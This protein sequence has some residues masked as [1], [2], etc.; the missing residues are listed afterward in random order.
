MEC[1][2]DST[3]LRTWTYDSE[4]KRVVM[5]ILHWEVCLWVNQQRCHWVGRT[6]STQELTTLQSEVD[7]NKLNEPTHLMWL[8]AETTSTTTFTDDNNNKWINQ[9]LLFLILSVLWVCVCGR[10]N[11]SLPDHHLSCQTM[12]N[13]WVQLQITFVITNSLCVYFKTQWPSQSHVCTSSGFPVTPRWWSP[14]SRPT[15]VFS[16]LDAWKA[17]MYTGMCW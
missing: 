16:N 13:K 15:V 5:D 9:N 10:Y 4:T 6:Q 1:S 8:A 12:A 3:P 7:H 11:T 14:V 17:P 2:S